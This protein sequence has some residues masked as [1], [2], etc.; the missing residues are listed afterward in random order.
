M[1]QR[2]VNMDDLNAEEL[3]RRGIAAARVGE[4][5]EAQLFLTEVTRRD[6]S[7]ADAWLWL[8]SV[9]TNPQV[10][11]DYFERVL[12]LR[13]GDA[14]AQ[15]G[16]DRLVEKFGKGVLQHDSE[17][18]V[19]HCHWHPDRETGLRCARCNKPICPDCARK[20]P[21]GWRCKEC[22]KELRSPL[23]KVSPK[24]YVMG[25]AVGLVVALGAAALMYV[26]GRFWFIPFFVAAPAGG[27]VADLTSRGTGGKRGRGVQLVAGIAVVV[28]ATVV[29]WATNY[30]PLGMLPGSG[31]GLLIFVLLG[32]G[33]AFYRLR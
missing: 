11:R 26:L 1:T 2:R 14:G 30:G 16:L 22:A 28:G 23:Y 10:K 32:A 17:V 4:A 7:Q 12:R 20:H 21:V 31:F 8:A 25:F 3:L 6:E 9:E 13:P 5:D 19:L 29:F 24:Q 33:A 27:V 18:D 15:D